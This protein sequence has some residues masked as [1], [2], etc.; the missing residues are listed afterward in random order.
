MLLS[1]FCSATRVALHPAGNIY[2]YIY[3]CSESIIMLAKVCR[4]HSYNRLFGLRML[5]V[6]KRLGAAWENCNEAVARDQFTQTAGAAHRGA[7]A[8]R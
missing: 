1:R 8:G 4:S 2:I 7:V 3:I 6:H 5:V